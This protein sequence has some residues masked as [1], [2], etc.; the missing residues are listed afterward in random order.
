[1][2]NVNRVDMLSQIREAEP[3]ADTRRLIEEIGFEQPS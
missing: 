2:R 3:Q 1:V